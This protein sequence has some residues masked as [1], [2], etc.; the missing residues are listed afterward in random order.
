MEYSDWFFKINDRI[1]GPIGLQELQWNVKTGVIVSDTLIREGVDGY[2]ERAALIQ[3]LFQ[4]TELMPATVVQQAGIESN[5]CMVTSVAASP[6]Q[7]TIRWLFALPAGLLAALFVAIPIHLFVMVNFGGWGI[8]DPVIEIRDPETLRQIEYFLQAMFGFLVFVYV[9]TRIV[10]NH[11]RLFSI[12]CACVLMFGLHLLAFGCNSSSFFK[13]EGI[14]IEHGPL[15]V[16]AQLTGSVIAIWLI[17]K[18]ENAS[19]AQNI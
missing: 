17:W 18:R 19:I 9:S 1:Y 8:N 4:K 13:E 6:V 16:L 2:W 14:Y 10:P 12:L 5:G 3:G 15:T 7:S 11:K